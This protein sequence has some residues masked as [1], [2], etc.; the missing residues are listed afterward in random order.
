[1]A[2]AARRGDR[3][4]SFAATPRRHRRADDPGGVEAARVEAAVRRGAQPGRQLVAGGDG[5]QHGRPVGA[6]R[7]AGGQGRGDHHA[8]GMHDGGGQRVVEVER[9]GQRAVG[10]PGPGG[11]QASVARDEGGFRSAPL[12]TGQREGHP[13]RRLVDGCQHDPQRVEQP[14]PHQSLM[15]GR[16]V[17]PPDA[18]APIREHARK[19]FCH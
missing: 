11:R 14:P 13:A 6:R 10:E 17:C 18:G 16:D 2:S 19:R 12:V 5:A 15:L 9:V 3:P 8:A 4:A 1:M 7:L